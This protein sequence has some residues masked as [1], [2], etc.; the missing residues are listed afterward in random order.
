MILNVI[1]AVSINEV[2]GNKDSNSLPWGRKYPEDLKFFQKM[3][4]NNRVIMGRNTFESIGSKPLK[5]RDN[6]VIT[7]KDKIEGARCFSSLTKYITCQSLEDVSLTNWIIGGERLY[8]EALSLP[9]TKNVYITLIPEIVEGYNLTFFP[10]DGLKDYEFK[11]TFPLE[12]SNLKVVK[13]SRI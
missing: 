8:K 6:V 1:A 2:I 7:S 9:E 3:T 11:G 4:T 13:Y 10:F 12:G 5:N